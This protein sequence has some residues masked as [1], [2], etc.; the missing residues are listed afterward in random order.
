MNAPYTSLTHHAP[1]LDQLN[2]TP[3]LRPFDPAAMGFAA[4]LSRMLMASPDARAFPEL[5]ALA[6]WLRKANLARLQ[7]STN[8]A[9]AGRLLV[10]RGTVFH[11]APSNVDSI[12]V[13]SWMYSLLA[14][15]RNILRISSRSS[16]QTQFLVRTIT[17]LLDNEAHAAIARRT[18]IVQYPSN[19]VA[20]ALFSSACDVR[21]IWGGDATVTQVRKVPLAPTATEVAFANKYSLALIGTQG[22][23]A[24]TDA[25]RD[26]AIQN[27]FNDAYWFDQ[28]ACSS[29]R[30]V[31]WLGDRDRVEEARSNF[32][33]R[34]QAL[35]AEKAVQFASIDYVNK[36]LSTHTIAVA[37]DTVI[38]E[39]QNNTLTRLWLEEPR[40]VADA[41][42]G[43]GLFLESYLEQLADMV[44]LLSRKVQTL[45]YY[46]LDPQQFHA[47]VSATPLQGMDRI[48]PFGQALNFSSVWDGFDL[49]RTFTREISIH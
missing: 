18:L 31:L 47:F 42:C 30:T 44:P 28:M 48:V 27:F 10:A 35:I 1:T 41:H 36:L 40:I 29:P 49:Y 32:W 6:Y 24:A 16:G 5:I 43:T 33:G 21:V 37:T 39:T 7:Q 45:S 8:D 15:N 23:L 9:N 3:L 22:W 17:D 2:E 11:I 13:Y 4:D 20:T 34:L 14:G 46:G 25:Q 26:E 12:F 38:C 19:S